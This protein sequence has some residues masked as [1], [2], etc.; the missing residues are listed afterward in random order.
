[1]IAIFSDTHSSRG[2]ELEG[3]ALEAVREA[4]AVI[5]AGDFNSEAAL[6]AFQAESSRLYGVF[7]N[8]DSMSV[9]DRLPE[10][11]TVEHDGLRI[12]VT[13]RRDG[14]QTGLRMFG[15]SREAELVV[16]GHTHRPT[17]IETDDCLLLNPG[18]HADPRGN[19]PG[20][21]T[22]EVTENGVEGRLFDLDGVV[23]ETFEVE[24]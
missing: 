4:E 9:R 1:M 8:T 23:V 13:H 18:S 20:Y 3:A 22:L 2:H 6:E 10:A 11:R 17:V 21:A 7:G 12:A 15:R 16:S 14:G 19:R 5:H 24:S